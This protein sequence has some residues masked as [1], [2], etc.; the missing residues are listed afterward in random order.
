MMRTVVGDVRKKVSI[1]FRFRF[2]E[3]ILISIYL[4][5]PC[6]LSVFVNGQNP[7]TNIYWFAYINIT[8]KR[9]TSDGS[10][11][12]PKAHN[13]TVSG[14]SEKCDEKKRNAV[15]ML[16]MLTSVVCIIHKNYIQ[17]SN[18]IY[19]LI[20]RFSLNWSE[21]RAFNNNKYASK[22]VVFSV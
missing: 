9:K 1:C 17:S 14:S 7:C 3:S 11:C 8:A 16:P 15:I 4:I 6:P 2:S 10:P 21:M 18:F 5:F 12:K 19:A 22:L 20:K 13:N